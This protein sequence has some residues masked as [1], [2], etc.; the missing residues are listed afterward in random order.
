MTENQRTVLT[1]DAAQPLALIEN[2]R[3]N[4]TLQTQDGGR[5][6]KS[7]TNRRARVLRTLLS[8]GSRLRGLW[9]GSTQSS[10]DALCGLPR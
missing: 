2:G 10:E 5:D 1:A 9:R 3:R 8:S 6:D 4:A 7:L